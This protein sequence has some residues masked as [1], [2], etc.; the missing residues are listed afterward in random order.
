MQ[1]TIFILSGPAGVGKTTLWHEIQTEIPHVSKIITTTSRE[2]RPNEINGVDYHFLSRSEF[3][4][5]I[6]TG[7]FIE[8]ALVHTNL[9]GS[10]FS[11]L[12]RILGENKNPLYIIE[13]Q[14]MIHIKPILE[15]KWYQVKTIFLLPPSIDE[16]KNRLTIRGTETEEQYQIRLATALHELE[17]QDFYDIKVLNDNLEI[18][19][20]DL[21]KIFSENV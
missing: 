21:I 17:Q 3:E 14:G 4:S 5:K 2:I 1:N 8:Y 20:S 18:A 6:K 10:T 9:Y 12:E 11:E 7:D 16:L 13:P 19:K 15:Q